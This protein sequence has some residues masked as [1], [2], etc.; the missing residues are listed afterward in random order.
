MVANCLVRHMSEI[1]RTSIL[2]PLL[3]EKTALVFLHQNLETPE[4]PSLTKVIVASIRISAPCN[5]QLV[6]FEC[7]SGAMTED[8]YWIVSE[9]LNDFVFHQQH[10]RNNSVDSHK[11]KQEI[12]I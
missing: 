7:R 6:R 1:V 12:H 2:N 3:W 4:N 5:F 10:P 11:N 9:M 8:P